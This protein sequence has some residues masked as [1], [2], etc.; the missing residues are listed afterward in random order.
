MSHCL[1]CMH[2]YYGAWQMLRRDIRGG[3]WVEPRKRVTMKSFA[4][5][6]HIDHYCSPLDTSTSNIQ[7]ACT[8]IDHT[9]GIC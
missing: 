5:H 6:S 9:L 3:S 4:S 7:P 1:V 2:L 8:V